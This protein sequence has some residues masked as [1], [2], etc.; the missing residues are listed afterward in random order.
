[1]YG[2]FYTAIDIAFILQDLELGC[3]E[4]SKILDSIWENEKSLLSKQYRDN[5]RKFLL[6][7][8]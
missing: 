7:I 4:E 6:D 1:M 8:Y 2:L 5:K 3:R